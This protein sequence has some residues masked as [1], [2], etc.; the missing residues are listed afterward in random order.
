LLPPSPTAQRPAAEP[1]RQNFDGAFVQR[2][3]VAMVEVDTAGTSNGVVIGT[4]SKFVFEAGKHR[5]DDGMTDLFY[6][7]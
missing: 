6:A 3:V 7:E 5:D 2:E 4:R 1:S